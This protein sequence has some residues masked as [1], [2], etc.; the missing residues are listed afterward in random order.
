M[1]FIVSFIKNAV[2]CIFQLTSLIL[3]SDRPL[4]DQE[5][6]GGVPVD[7]HDGVKLHVP[8]LF[9]PGPRLLPQCEQELYPFDRPQLDQDAH[10]SGLIDGCAGGEGDGL[11]DRGTGVEVAL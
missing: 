1:F 9:N 5:E 4:L 3:L 6:Q 11:I 10:G 7:R 8:L 2:F